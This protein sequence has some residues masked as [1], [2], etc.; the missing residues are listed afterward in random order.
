MRLRLVLF[1]VAYVCFMFKKFKISHRCSILEASG[2]GITS[3]SLKLIFVLNTVNIA[4][5]SP[6]GVKEC[7]CI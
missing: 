5:H 7:L 3:Q 4:S 6:H 2:F 1:F